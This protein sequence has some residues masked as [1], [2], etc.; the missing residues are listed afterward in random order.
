[1]AFGVDEVAALSGYGVEG[2]E[3]IVGCA[4]MGGVSFLDTTS[5]AKKR[6]ENWMEVGIHGR[7]SLNSGFPDE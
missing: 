2:F 4:R 5:Q 1:M 3:D 7:D 6:K